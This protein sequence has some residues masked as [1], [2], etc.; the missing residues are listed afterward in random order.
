[1]QKYCVTK[2]LLAIREMLLYENNIICNSHRFSYKFAFILIFSFLT[3]Q[4]QESVFQQ[5]WWSGNEKY[6]CF[7]FVASRAV[8]QS[9]DEL[10]R[11][12]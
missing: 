6:F 4:N 1:M 5:S 10:N 9:H 8:L 3:N 2:V 7:L 11:L 12:L